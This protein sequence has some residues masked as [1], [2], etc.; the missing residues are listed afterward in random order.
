MQK[1]EYEQDFF[2]KVQSLVPA[3]RLH[4][5]EPMSRHTTFKIGG[6]ADFLIQ[7]ASAPEAAAVLKAALSCN[8]AVTI[9]GN[10]SNVLVRD[11]GIRGVVLKFDEHMGAIRHTGSTII[12]GAGATLADVSEYA[13]KQQLTGLEF[14]IGIPGSIGGAVFMNAG[15]YDGEISSVVSAVTAVCPDGNIRRFS[16]EKIHFTYRHSVFQ[17]NGCIICEI[18]LSLIP[19]QRN[20]I[21]R[22]MVDLTAKRESKQP[23][24]MPSAGSTFKRPPGYFAGTLIEQTGLKGLKIGGAQVSEKHAGFIVNAGNATANDVLSLI[25][26]VQQRVHEK[27]GVDLHPEVRVIG[28]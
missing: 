19:G 7:P 10:G 27:F 26:E 15:A 11:H 17:D 1:T 2:K 9:L 14:A 13:L 4:V 3:E 20:E 25:K 18:E 24:E 8:M 22:K 12:A 16:S 21:S 5:N 28:E 23:L 6:P